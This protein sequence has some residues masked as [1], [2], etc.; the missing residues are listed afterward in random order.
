[1]KKTIL[2]GLHEQF[3][4]KTTR[5]LTAL[6][7]GFLVIYG[8]GFLLQ[9]TGLIPLMLGAGSI[10]AGTYS[11]FLAVIAFRSKSKLAPRL[12]IRENEIA[13]KMRVF[14]KF[15]QI[16]P[17]EILKVEFGQYLVR[18]IMNKQE[19]VFSYTRNTEVSLEIKESIRE[20]CEEKEIQ[21][22]GG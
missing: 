11:L 16:T 21:V 20:W 14:G 2:L 18:F 8:I 22:V 7:S 1:M 3:T 19:K 5:I 10:V 17:N 6:T 9:Y 13:Y 15:E 12:E 4:R